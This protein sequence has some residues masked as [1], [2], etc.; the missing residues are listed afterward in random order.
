MLL[1]SYSMTI[2][3]RNCSKHFYTKHT[4]ARTENYLSPGIGMLSYFYLCNYLIYFS[5]RNVKFTGYLLYTYSHINIC[6][7]LLFLSVYLGFHLLFFLLLLSLPLLCTHLSTPL[8]LFFLPVFQY[9]SI[10]LSLLLHH[11]TYF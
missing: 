2:I 1:I 8:L 5:Y 3:I 9:H 4:G 6:M 10:H 7:Q 11:V